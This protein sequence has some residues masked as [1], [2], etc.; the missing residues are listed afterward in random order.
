MGVTIF[1]WSKFIKLTMCIFLLSNCCHS[2]NVPY[3]HLSL[4]DNEILVDQ[5]VSLETDNTGKDH[6]IVKIVTTEIEP[7]RTH[8]AIVTELEKSNL[9]LKELIMDL[10]AE[11]KAL[12]SS[13]ESDK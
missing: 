7:E 8:D 4:D 11:V 10:Q 9:D 12:R 13:H 1:Q 3:K 6:K 2:N 5:I